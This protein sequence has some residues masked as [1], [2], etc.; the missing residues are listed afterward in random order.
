MSSS[1][2]TILIIGGT[3]GIGEACAQ[4][5]HSIGKKVIITGRRS[6]RLE[7]IKKS[8]SGLE[9][10]TWDITDLPKIPE[11]IETIFQSHPDIDTVWINSG[12]QHSS[13]I[14]DLSSTTDEKVQ[15]EITT[16]ITAPMLIARHTIPRLVSRAPKTSTFMITSSG[17]AFIPVGSMFPVYCPTKAAIHSYMV[18]IRQALQK[19]NVN[20]IEIVPPLVEPTELGMEHKGQTS[21]LQPLPLEEFVEQ[22]FE[23]LEGDGEG[24]KEVAAGSARDRVKAWREGMGPLM[25]QLGG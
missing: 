14:S 17:L 16:N 6:T 1:I 4:R 2:N 8:L 18:G 9:T 10:Y 3:S 24:I 7:E 23:G 20:V 19:S 13:S 22:M 15:N 25:K 21:G 12:I 11:H 5:F